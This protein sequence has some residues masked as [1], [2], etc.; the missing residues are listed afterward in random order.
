MP[1]GKEPTRALPHYDITAR[2][3]LVYKDRILIAR[4]PTDE[5]LRRIVGVPRRQEGGRPKPHRR[6]RPRDPAR[7]WA[8]TYGLGTYSWPGHHA[9][10]HFRITLYFLPLRASSSARD[11]VCLGVLRLEVGNARQAIEYAFQAAN[12]TV[13]ALLQAISV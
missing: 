3:L 8:S 4:R 1:A 10:T 5:L 13:I 12:R 6:R 9:Y 11:V 7:N 2:W